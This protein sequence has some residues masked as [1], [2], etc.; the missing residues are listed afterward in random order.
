MMTIIQLP[1]LENAALN[2]VL[3]DV[4]RSRNCELNMDTYYSTGNPLQMTFFFENGLNLNGLFRHPSNWPSIL[5][6]RPKSANP[7]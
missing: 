4:Y 5:A 6:G 2:Q 7:G 1:N 3:E